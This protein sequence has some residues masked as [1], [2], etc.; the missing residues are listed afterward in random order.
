MDRLPLIHNANDLL[1]CKMCGGKVGEEHN[2]HSQTSIA[3]KDVKVIPTL[4][5]T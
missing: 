1:Y 4:G 5:D 3:S 2:Q